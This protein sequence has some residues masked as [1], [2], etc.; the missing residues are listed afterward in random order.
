MRPDQTVVTIQREGR[1]VTARTS[2]P[3]P[4]DRAAGSGQSDYPYGHLTMPLRQRGLL[5]T[6]DFGLSDYI[7]HAEL[8]DGSAFVISPP[9][10]PPTDHPPGYPES[11]LV[12]RGHPENSTLHEVVYDSAPGG[13]H[14]RSGGSVTELLTAVDARLD[15]LGVPHPQENAADSVLHRA[16]LVPVV[17]YRD[18]FHRLPAAM[19][20]PAE[21]RQAVTRAVDMLRANGFTYACEADLLEPSVPVR[22][23]HPRPLGDRIAE[24][25]RSISQADHTSEAVAALSELTTPGDG[26]LDRV[27]EALEATA[28]WWE[29]LGASADPLYAD[30]LRRV[31]NQLG[32]SALE[33]RSLRNELADRH[34]TRPFRGR[35]AN[36]PSEPDKYSSGSEP[37]QLPRPTA[38]PRRNH[39]RSCPPHQ[40]PGVLLLLR[41]RP[42]PV[43]DRKA[44]PPYRPS[45][46]HGACLALRAITHARSPTVFGNPDFELY[47]NAGRDS[48]QIHAYNT[49]QPTMADLRRRSV[50]GPVPP[51]VGPLIDQW[52]KRITTGEPSERAQLLILALSNPAD[53]ALPRLHELLQQT[54]T[55]FV[56]AGATDAGTDLHNVANQL[57]T[58]DEDLYQAACDAFVETTAQT[59]RTEAARRTSPAAGTTAPAPERPA[60]GPSTHPAPPSQAPPRNR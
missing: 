8:P 57:G 30:R 52:A 6:V 32:V 54:I 20:D 9:Q 29:G 58:L 37:R 24:V 44:D 27:L 13:P 21:Q 11:W 41:P 40:G 38:H 18:R 7:V 46:N 14:A 4:Q 28:V 34:S 49:G 33:I 12:T 56:Q 15:Q 45:R 55:G 59:R 19:T 2:G 47:D 42:D 26:V 35:D 17:R 5:C 3:L 51:R 22:R 36:A 23:D 53:G 39:R 16:G 1:Y 43:A 50:K 25:I 48:E 31:G 60:N 10:E